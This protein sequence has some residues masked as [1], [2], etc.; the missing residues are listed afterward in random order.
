[1]TVNVSGFEILC[2]EVVTS[3]QVTD[4]CAG[5]ITN[6]GL[7]LYVW[8]GLMDDVS[9]KYI[10]W[11]EELIAESSTRDFILSGVIPN[12]PFLYLT[13]CAGYR[14]SIEDPIVPSWWGEGFMLMTV[15]PESSQTEDNS[16]ICL[17]TGMAVGGGLVYLARKHL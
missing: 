2:D 16:I 9:G 6:S 14:Q 4:I 13:L 15:C 3:G 10:Y 17:L 1:M 11:W 5:N 7:E 8:V 12:V